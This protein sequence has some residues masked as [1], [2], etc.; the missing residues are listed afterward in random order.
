MTVYGLSI[1]TI[2]VVLSLVLTTLIKV[3]NQKQTNAIQTLKLLTEENKAK[4]ELNKSLKD[5]IELI[6]KAYRDAQAR[7]RELEQKYLVEPSGV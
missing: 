7:V 3:E 1:E 5:H 2:A 4:D 6:T